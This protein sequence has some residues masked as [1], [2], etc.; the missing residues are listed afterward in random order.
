MSVGK[1]GIS[2]P[3]ISDSTIDRYR[4]GWASRG[5]FRNGMEVSPRLDP[6]E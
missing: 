1:V 2:M 6:C 5:E 4:A 3:T